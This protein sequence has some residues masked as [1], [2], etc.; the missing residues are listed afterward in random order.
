ML[1]LSNHA[2]RRGQSQSKSLA[3]DPQPVRAP[4]DQ[5]VDRAGRPERQD[6]K[7]DLALEGASGL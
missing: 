2:E 4:G 6:S 1:P 3:R 5:E 7:E